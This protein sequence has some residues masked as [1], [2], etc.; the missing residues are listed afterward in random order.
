MNNKKR[1]KRALKYLVWLVV[2]V[3]VIM[4][5]RQGLNAAVSL[6]NICIPLILGCIIAFAFKHCS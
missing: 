5:F 3:L 4:Y 2:A 1:E 6:L